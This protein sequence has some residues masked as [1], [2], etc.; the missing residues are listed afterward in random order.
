[1]RRPRASRL[2][3]LPGLLALWFFVSEVVVGATMPPVTL[4]RGFLERLPMLLEMPD[5]EF[6]RL[7]GKGRGD[8]DPVS[9][10]PRA[11]RNRQL[12]RRVTGVRR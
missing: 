11:K 12:E 9:V 5:S 3:A 8:D 4:P 10:K 2:G 6:Q 7:L 1:M